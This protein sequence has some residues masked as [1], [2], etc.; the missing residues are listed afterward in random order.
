MASSRRFIRGTHRWCFR[1]GEWA[2]VLEEV[3]VPANQRYPDRV[4]YVVRFPD[5]KRD[6]WR[7]DDPVAGYEFSNDPLVLA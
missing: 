3:L 6:L 5:G 4:C 1:S 2:E 7:V